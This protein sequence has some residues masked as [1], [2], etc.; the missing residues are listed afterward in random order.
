MSLNDAGLTRETYEAEKHSFGYSGTGGSRLIATFT[1]AALRCE[2]AGF[3]GVE[4]H[5]ANGYLFTQF[6]APADNPRTD[7]WGGAFENRIRLSLSVARAIR[8]VI[9]ETMPLMYRVSAITKVIEIP[10]LFSKI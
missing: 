3:D 8:K 1:Q 6:L 2:Q 4:V 5:G 7:A 9:P 10:K